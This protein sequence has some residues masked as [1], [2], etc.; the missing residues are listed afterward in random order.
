ML[1]REQ[2]TMEKIGLLIQ[3]L[4]AF[5]TQRLVAR[6][7]HSRQTKPQPVI[8]LHS[9]LGDILQPDGGALSWRQ[10]ANTQREY[11]WTLLTLL[12]KEGLLTRAQSIIILLT[13][14]K[15]EITHVSFTLITVFLG[16]IKVSCFY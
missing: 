13:G 10:T 16:S 4:A 8:C 1:D 14:L 5:P 6:V 2:V 3:V 12:Q 11:I 7:E 15:V 9:Q